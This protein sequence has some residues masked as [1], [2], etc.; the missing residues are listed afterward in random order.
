VNVYQ[1][2]APT[3]YG[4]FAG[5]DDLFTSASPNALYWGSRPLACKSPYPPGNRSVTWPDGCPRVTVAY[6]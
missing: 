4:L 3:I 6:R 5:G 2:G 1:E